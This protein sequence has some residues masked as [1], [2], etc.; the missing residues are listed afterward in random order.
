MGL[1]LTLTALHSFLTQT[2][3]LRDSPFPQMSTPST[4]ECRHLLHLFNSP[5]L[6]PILK[7]LNDFTFSTFSAA[8]RGSAFLFR[9]LSDCTMLSMVIMRA[10]TTCA[11]WR[12]IPW[13]TAQLILIQQL[14]SAISLQLLFHLDLLLSRLLCPSTA[15][16]TSSRRIRPCLDL[17]F[18]ER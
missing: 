4:S 7:C 9:I 14:A 18:K 2:F 12:F 16:S 15:T 8:L 6:Q 17:L 10:G 11:S 5:Q 1:Q 3:K 13:N